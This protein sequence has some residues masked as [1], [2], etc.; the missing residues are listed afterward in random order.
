MIYKNFG[1]SG[2]MVPAIL[3]T[4]YIE[5]IPNDSRVAKGVDTISA[6]QVTKARIEKVQKLKVIADERNQTVAQLA[7]AWSLR[8]EVGLH[9]L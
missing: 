7:I 3:T 5:G 2:L 8:K 1:K 6:D 9:Q 4:K